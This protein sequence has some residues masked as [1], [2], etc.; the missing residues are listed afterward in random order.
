M[1][2]VACILFLTVPV[3]AL[4]VQS[5]N[6]NDTTTN[7]SVLI[8]SAF[9]DAHDLN[10]G[11]T[12]NGI[13]K[14]NGNAITDSGIP[15]VLE[16][17]SEG[18]TIDVTDYNWV[19]I[20][21][22]N[23]NVATVSYVTEGGKL[24]ITFTPGTEKGTTKISV[25][26]DAKYPHLSLGTWNMNLNFDYTVTNEIIDTNNKP[27]PPTAEDINDFYNSNVAI[28]VRCIDRNDSVHNGSLRRLAVGS[29]TI[30]EVEKYDG[31]NEDLSQTEWSY[32]CKVHINQQYY[33]N[34][35]NRNFQSSKGTHYLYGTK[36]DVFAPF[37][38]FNGGYCSYAGATLSKGWYCLTEDAP[39]YVDI[40]HNNLLLTTYKIVREYYINGEKAATVKGGDKEGYVGDII[41]GNDLV[42]N[43]PSWRYYTVDGNKIE[44]E[45]VNS[46]PEQLI[47]VEDSSQN[48]ITLK[49]IKNTF[50]NI[51]LQKKFE[52][53]K[54]IEIPTDFY[55]EYY[56][57][58]LE[59]P[60]GTLKL[61]DATKIRDNLYEWEVELP[62]EKDITFK[63]YNYQSGRYELIGIDGN[64]NVVKKDHTIPNITFRFPENLAGG[65]R[66]ITNYYN[67]AAI[68]VHYRVEYYDKKGNIIKETSYRTDFEGETVAPTDEDYIIDG[69]IFDEA[70]NRNILSKELKENEEN[71]LKLYFYK[72]A[73][74]LHFVKAIDGR[75]EG[76]TATLE[77]SFEKMQLKKDDA[78]KFHITLTNKDTG[79]IIKGILDSKAGLTISDIPIGTYLITESDDMYFDF[80]DMKANN[81]DGVSLEKSDD[82]YILMISD[83]ISVDTDFEITVNNR[84]EPDRPY[85]DKKEKVNLF[86]F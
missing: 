63:E 40:T 50:T 22:S 48:I 78:Y 7:T 61:S 86:K 26:V 25:G 1:I 15:N 55:M 16:S 67:H 14:L 4:D 70:D 8:K 41:N 76:T 33:L 17:T 47:L 82:G 42:E 57:D 59:T 5:D 23:P 45:Y 83:T 81:T 44:F 20:T 84:I 6:I 74:N 69:Y 72:P 62:T 27:E 71:V 54:P 36:K 2:L 43:N 52:S 73:V 46:N 12:C 32:M 34:M 10:M 66:T 3:N 51:H 35:W 30:G 56:Y 28:I 85:E 80:V 77:E 24:S 53:I 49:Y 19:H 11:D 79:D 29:Y 18:R 68:T 64:I 58:D 75:A 9:E 37:Y 65:T 39:V 13:I 31:S 38:Y 21:N 60:K